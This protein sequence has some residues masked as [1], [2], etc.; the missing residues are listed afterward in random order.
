[1]ALSALQHSL[2]FNRNDVY[3]ESISLNNFKGKKILLSFFRDATCPFCHTRLFELNFHKDKW[4][5]Q[6]LEVIAVFT[7]TDDKILKY[8][9]KNPRPFRMIGDPELSIYQ[10]YGVN[11]SIKGV[12]KGMFF[13]LGKMFK[14][15]LRGGSLATMLQP[16]PTIIPADFLINEQGIIEQVWYGEDPSDHIAMEKINAFATS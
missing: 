10:Q 1:M 11:K 7:S 6:N 5:D 9:A 14:G 8:V 3:G 2:D 4:K 15:Y 13:R 16:H 12:I